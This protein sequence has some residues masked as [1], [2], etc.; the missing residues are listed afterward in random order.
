MR[1]VHLLCLFVF[2]CFG[3]CSSAPKA[4]GEMHDHFFV[5]PAAQAP[6]RGWAVLLPGS[7]G[8]KIFDDEQHYFRA[9]EELNALGWDALIVDYKP[10]YFSARDAPKLSTGGKIA[11]VTEQAVAW[12]KE[13]GRLQHG[14][15]V[16]MAW[17][18]GA[19]GVWH[20][21]TDEARSG[22]LGVDA[23][24]CFYPSTE[25]W[26]AKP[27]VPVLIQTGAADDVT[28]LQE[29]SK[30]M[31]NASAHGDLVALHVHDNARHGFDVSSL[32]EKREVRVLPLIGPKGTFGYNQSA[33]KTAWT[34]VLLF[35]SRLSPQ[36]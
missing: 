21:A 20:L 14:P 9:A 31:V 35:L 30:A 24:V 29:I 11:W 5:R 3:A 13:Q 19:E 10:A 12:A 22:A 34:N 15:G 6:A 18:L 26:K 8:L 17:S 4:T 2:V 23:A 27:V 36:D 32:P 25:E 1:A 16:L 33:A 7:S 28:T